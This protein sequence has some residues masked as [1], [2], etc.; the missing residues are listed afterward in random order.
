MSQ[1]QM[2]GAMGNVDPSTL[3]LN[4]NIPSN[5]GMNFNEFA[6]PNMLNMGN[7]GFYSM[8]PNV[9]GQSPNN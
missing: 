5:N 3:N 1:M 4:S 9:N 7:M 2:F 6:N 8:Y